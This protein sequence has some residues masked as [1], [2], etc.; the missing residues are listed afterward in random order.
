MEEERWPEDITGN[1]PAAQAEGITK[2]YTSEDREAFRSIRSVGQLCQWSSPLLSAVSLSYVM[3]VRKQQ[4]SSV[5]YTETLKQAGANWRK[6]SETE[7][8]VCHWNVLSSSQS[9]DEIQALRG[10]VQEEISGISIHFASP[11]E[12]R[13]VSRMPL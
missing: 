8:A 3:D 4:E 10:N 1:Q 2:D 6:L 11:I 5:S 7:K 12:S 13:S 9:T